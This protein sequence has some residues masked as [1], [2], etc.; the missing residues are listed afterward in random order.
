[1]QGGVDQMSRVKIVMDERERGQI[2]EE[3]LKLESRLDLT[4]ET[5]EYGDYIVSP[6]CAIERKRGDDFVA[7]IFDQRLFLQLQ[8]LRE[9][10][11]YPVLIL[12]DSKRL[13]SRKFVNPTSI[14]GAL[15][16]VSTRMHIPIIPTINEA[17][18]AALVFTLAQR[19]Q[20]L[21]WNLGELSPSIQPYSLQKSV[22]V[23]SEDQEY[24]L[25]G[26]VDIGYTRAQQLLDVF[27]TPEIIL[28]A[29]ESTTVEVT[30]GGNPKKLSGILSNVSGIGPKIVFRNQQLLNT[31][32][33]R[34]KKE[35]LKTKSP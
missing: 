10:Y 18:T 34:A 16:Y 35:K 26:L 22:A 31:S 7:S 23:S 28:Y 25:Q 8:K 17:D 5:L 30:S 20:Q 15:I 29:L 11:L 3:F 6:R 13:F 9:A 2:R 27:Q 14:Y 33:K 24:F 32:Y 4:I 19:E 12:E 21:G 1:M